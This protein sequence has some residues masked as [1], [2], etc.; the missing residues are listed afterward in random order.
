MPPPEPI[1]ERVLAAVASRL[2]TIQAGE[3]YWTSP[4]VDRA[5][6]ALTQ[7]TARLDAG[8]RILGVLRSSLSTYRTVA[9]D[10]MGHEFRFAIWGYVKADGTVGAG[11]WL[12][13][14][15]AD[16]VRCLLADPGLGGLVRDLAP[17]P[18]GTTDT[19]EGA[20][21][22]YAAFTQDWLAQMHEAVA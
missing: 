17:D 3:T 19:D 13:R 12:E 15:W 22:P 5:L 10:L 9:H 7:Y 8:D 6:L 14:L 4:I 21:E 1:R 11:T 2:Q 16:H 18:E 20:L